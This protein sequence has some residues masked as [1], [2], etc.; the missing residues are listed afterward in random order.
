M[1]Q[2]WR[3]STFVGLDIASIQ[4]DLHALAKAQDMLSVDLASD[5]IDAAGT[6]W[7]DVATRVTW[8]IADL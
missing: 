5:T 8:R 3:E 1:A 4:T 6:D 7:H 2:Q